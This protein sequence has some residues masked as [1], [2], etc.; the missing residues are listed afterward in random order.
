MHNVEVGAVVAIPSKPHPELSSG[1]GFAPRTLVSR[2]GVSHCLV[3]R[4]EALDE[5]RSML[6]RTATVDAPAVAMVTGEAGVGK[7]RLLQELSTAVEVPVVA[8]QARAG[9]GRRAFALLRDMVEEHLDPAGGLPEELA[10]WHQPLGHVLEPLVFLRD[11]HED[12]H[13]HQREELVRA[14]VALLCHLTASG[15]ALVVFEDL[16]WADAESLEVFSRLS[17]S[18]ARLL[19]VGTFRGEEFDRSGP[20]AAL[21]AELDRQAATSHLPLDG[22]TRQ[23]LAEFLQGVCGQPPG[24]AT[25]ERLHQRTRGNPFF[26]EE[27]LAALAPR[28]SS[29]DQAAHVD[30]DTLAEVPLPWNTS[31]AALRRLEG[32]DERSRTMLHTGAILGDRFDLRMLAGVLDEDLETLL[33]RVAEL[34]REG[35][36]VERTATSFAFRHALTRE[37][38]AGELLASERRDIHARAL[39]V[40]AAEDTAPPAVL[41]HHAVA[42]DRTR[43]AA[44]HACD[45]ARATAHGGAPR[46]TLRWASISLEHEPDQVEMHQLAAQAAGQLGAFDEASR[47]AE[48]W[49]ALAADVDDRSSEALAGSLLSW[50]RWWAGHHDAAGEAIDAAVTVVE[51]LPA[52]PVQAEVLASQARYLMATNRPTE[53]VDRAD[54]AVEIAERAGDAR[55]RAKGWLHKAAGILD[56]PEHQRHEDL[57]LAARL[58]DRA[59]EE[60]ARLGDV[61]TLAGALHNRLVPDQPDDLPIE[62]SWELLDEAREVADRYGLERL[63]DKLLLLESHLAVIDGDL[64]RAERALEAAQR[65]SLPS[66]EAN[67]RAAIDASLGLETGDLDRAEA[68]HAAQHGLLGEPGGTVAEVD[69]LV[70]QA[71]IAAHR[72][73]KANAESAFRRIGPAVESVCICVAAN[74]WEVAL[75]ALDGGVTPSL[76]REL[77]ASD[78]PHAVPRHAG[79]VAHVHGALLAAEGEPDQA[80]ETLRRSLDHERRGRRATLLADAHQ[81]LAEL[82]GTRG[83]RDQARVHAADAL[84]LLDRWPGPRRAAAEALQRRLGGRGGLAHELFTARELEVIGLVARGYTNSDIAERLFITRKTA[85]THISNILAKTGFERRTQVAVWAVDE[86]IAEPRD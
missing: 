9:E 60:S 27:L 36:L 32:L 45:A 33:P 46:E 31:E 49:R 63:A 51:G 78:A 77:M 48:R 20:L 81:R 54:Q 15:P 41:A 28:R 38:A 65:P 74:W 53:A 40:L 30:A 76:V 44:V 71:A 10:R 24:T 39:D 6:Q 70:V 2:R 34:V 25:V 86:G 26:L 75:A 21:L 43:D 14:G 29:V 61:D 11:H 59:R 47:H 13:D 72:R 66:L 56:S 5:L 3:G 58:L 42:A 55:T 35:V 67:W 12:G 62:R 22:L 37:A 73:D 57:Q 50:T 64:R 79:L 7:T 52:S 17:R 19:L 83:D 84:V 16:Q 68:A 8:G 85:A 80:I 18:D 4:R 1:A 82:L 23:E 69:L